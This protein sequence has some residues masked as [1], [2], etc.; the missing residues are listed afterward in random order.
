MNKLIYQGHRVLGRKAKKIFIFAR[1]TH[2]YTRDPIIKN[3]KF[4][5]WFSGPLRD[6][7]SISKIKRSKL[8][9]FYFYFY[10]INIFFFCDKNVRGEKRLQRSRWIS[11]F[12]SFMKLKL[13]IRFGLLNERF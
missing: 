10:V 4:K 11:E 5:N 9:R 3:H 2:Y 1:D 7:R 6:I 13:T 8:N 12:K